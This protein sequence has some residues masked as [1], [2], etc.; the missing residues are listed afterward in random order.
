M[1]DD[2]GVGVR[3]EDNPLGLELL[4]Q[5]PIV[6]DYPV[7]DHPKAAWTVEVRVGVALFRLAMG[8]PTGVTDAAL[9]LRTLGLETGGEIRELAL[10]TQTGQSGI[11]SNGGNAR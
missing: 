1:R 3:A 10:S 6:L 9:P 8:R 5:A 2:L 11:S 4:T 7:L